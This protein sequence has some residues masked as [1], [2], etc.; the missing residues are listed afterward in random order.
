M[1]LY[2]L[3][4]LLLLTVPSQSPLLVL[5]LP[6]P[7]IWCHSRSSFCTFS[8][9]IGLISVWLYLIPNV[10]ASQMLLISQSLSSP[11]SLLSPQH[12]Y[13]TAQKIFPGE[14][15]TQIYTTC[16]KVTIFLSLSCHSYRNLVPAMLLRPW[17]VSPSTLTSKLEIILLFHPSH[18]MSHP[19]LSILPL[20]D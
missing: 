19:V 20:L 5:F 18:P 16:L 8:P 12:L 4:F 6:F 3:G 7:Y 14:H 13:P 15:P 1:I 11:K 2:F 17:T 10:T 9:L